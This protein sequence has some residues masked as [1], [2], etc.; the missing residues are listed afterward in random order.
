VKE[1]ERKDFFV[2]VSDSENSALDMVFGYSNTQGVP[3][4]M[5]SHGRG[6]GRVSSSL[7]R[8]GPVSAQPYSLFSFSF[9][10]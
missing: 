1:K 3:C 9:C 4:K 8:A 6:R 2:N 7:G 5:I 10:P